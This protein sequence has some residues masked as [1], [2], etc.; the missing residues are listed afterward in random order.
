MY[1]ETEWIKSDSANDRS[2]PADEKSVE[3]VKMNSS[4]W[5]ESVA[6]LAAQFHCQDM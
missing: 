5:Q 2:A 3:A 1:T 6:K 4:E